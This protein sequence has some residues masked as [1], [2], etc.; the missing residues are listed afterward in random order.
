VVFALLKIINRCI[1]SLHNIAVVAEFT[2]RYRALAQGQPRANKRWKSSLPLRQCFRCRL[3]GHFLR[4][5][6]ARSFDSQR[7][8]FTRINISRGKFSNIRLDDDIYEHFLK[9]FP[10]F[11]DSEKL[12]V[13]NEDEMKSPQGKARWRKFIN[14]YEKKVDDFNFG[15]LIR[16]NS[17]NEYSEDN[18]IFAVRMQF[19]AIEIAR[20]RK[21][22]N[23]WISGQ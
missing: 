10:E 17:S 6:Q 7:K 3:T 2:A 4:R 13:L 22:L 23:D 11:E 8:Y 16:T 9:D 19:Y 18:T 15:T 21:G 1:L 20:N 5:F 12:K 14:E